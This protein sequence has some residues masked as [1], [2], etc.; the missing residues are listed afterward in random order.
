M[1][2]FRA[3]IGRFLSKLFCGSQV[4]WGCISS[5]SRC[6]CGCCFSA[7]VVV[8]AVIVHVTAKVAV[9]VPAFVVQLF[10]APVVVIIMSWKLTLVLPLLWSC[11]V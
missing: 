1:F 2:V 3:S 10:E 8:D 7:N 6:C 11:S 4:I 5:C 9:A